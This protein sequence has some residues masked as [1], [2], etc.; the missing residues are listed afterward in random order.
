MRGAREWNWDF[1]S[2][3]NLHFIRTTHKLWNC[4]CCWL[5]VQEEG[6]FHLQ[7]P[8]THSWH[9]G[10][11]T[12]LSLSTGTPGT[13]TK[14]I[15][16]CLSNVKKGRIFFHPILAEAMTT[17]L[18]SHSEIMF[19][20]YILEWVEVI[21]RCGSQ[22]YLLSKPYWASFLTAQT[23]D[24]KLETPEGQEWLDFL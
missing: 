9:L 21:K 13:M 11:T 4:I 5:A 14:A 24:H 8:D 23:L 19:F 7:L 2:V 3:F 20:Y 12:V 15:Y 10:V 1:L 18:S 17:P 22:S 16:L 6:T